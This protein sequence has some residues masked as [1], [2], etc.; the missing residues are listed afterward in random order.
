MYL[1]YNLDGYSWRPR[2]S[3]LWAS[4]PTAAGVASLPPPAAASAVAVCIAVAVARR[5]SRGAAAW[6]RGRPPCGPAHTLFWPIHWGQSCRCWGF[7]SVTTTARLTKTSWEKARTARLTSVHRR[8]SK[9]RPLKL[10]KALYTFDKN[11]KKNRSWTVLVWVTF[12]CQLSS[13]SLYIHPK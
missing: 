11:Q 5:R 9:R 12:C 6:Q 13:L 3:A 7:C 1:C 8:A 2:Q 4:A 10:K